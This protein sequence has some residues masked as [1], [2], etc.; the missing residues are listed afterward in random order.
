MAKGTRSPAHP[1]SPP[2]TRELSVLHLWNVPLP[3][4]CGMSGKDT[5]ALADAETTKF[6]ELWNA[7]LGLLR[8]ATTFHCSWINPGVCFFNIKVVSSNKTT[9]LE[10]AKMKTGSFQ[11]LCWA[12]RPPNRSPTRKNH[13]YPI[14]TSAYEILTVCQAVRAVRTA[15]KNPWHSPHALAQAC[16]RHH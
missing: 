7:R 15:M 5:L 16:G 3:F 11:S 6:P 1:H 12:P 9:L 10:I 4:K 8:N 2:E 13:G 14:S